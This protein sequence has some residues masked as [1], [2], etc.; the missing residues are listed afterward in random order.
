MLGAW[1]CGSRS[2]VGCED[3]ELK[4]R[5]PASLRNPHGRAGGAKE[6]IPESDP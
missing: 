4:V 6:G 3:P 1:T 2:A 5:S